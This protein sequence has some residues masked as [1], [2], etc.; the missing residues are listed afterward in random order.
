MNDTP[1]V[2]FIVSQIY[3]VWSISITKGTKTYVHVLYQH[4][5]AFKMDHLFEKNEDSFNLET[6]FQGSYHHHYLQ[7]S[8]KNCLN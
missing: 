4:T 2:E 7:R 6:R 5:N 1:L 8:L 3:G